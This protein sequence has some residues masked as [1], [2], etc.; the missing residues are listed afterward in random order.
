MIDE[1]KLS[2]HTEPDEETPKTEISQLE[3]DFEDSVEEMEHFWNKFKKE[4]DKIVNGQ[5]KDMFQ[6]QD[7]SLLVDVYVKP[8]LLRIKAL[9]L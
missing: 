7:Q 4:I 1:I 2:K 9:I 3:E 5:Y 6:N 8:H